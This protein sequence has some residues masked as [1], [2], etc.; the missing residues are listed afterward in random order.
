MRILII[1]VVSLWLPLAAAEAFELDAAVEARRQEAGL[2]R[3]C[4]LWDWTVHSHTA[5]HRESKAKIVLPSSQ[6]AGIEG[7]SPTEI[8]I[9]GDAVYFRWDFPGGYQEDSMLFAENRR[10]EGTFRTS[11]GA[12]GAINGK[13]LSSCQPAATGGPDKPESKP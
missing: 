11:A 13:R 4:G 10:L 12:V 5:N 2:A 6:A 9:Y 3:L 7:P 1:V 8:R